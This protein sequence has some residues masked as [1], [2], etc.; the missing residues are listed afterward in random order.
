MLLRRVQRSQSAFPGVKIKLRGG[1]GLALPLL[2]QYREFFA[3]E[4]VLGIPANCVFCR[5]TQPARQLERRYCLTQLPQRSF[6]RFR[7]RAHCWA[8]Q[9]ASATKASTPLKGN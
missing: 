3:I 5:C 8:R 1:A 9:A 7:H 4:Y 2:H 6:S